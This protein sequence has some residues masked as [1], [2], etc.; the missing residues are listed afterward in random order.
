MISIDDLER[1]ALNTARLVHG[2]R[3]EQ[4]SAPT[5]CPQWDVRTLTNHALWV[6]EMFGAATEGRPPAS[7]RDA[8]LLGDDPGDS[9]DRAASSTV[10][11]WRA[12][13]FDGTLRIPVGELPAPVAL[14]INTCD[15][16]LHGWDI[17]QATGQDAQLDD[18][19]G[20][21]LLTFIKQFLPAEPRDENFGPVVEV[22]SDA[23]PSDRLLAY[24]GRKP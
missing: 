15:V 6:V 8:D 9:F 19:L 16:Y 23:S 24:S 1:A 21:E 17:A 20:A 11:A 5:P 3:A 2:V 18:E 12:R 22:A 13:G 10:T 7:A 14:G 4:W